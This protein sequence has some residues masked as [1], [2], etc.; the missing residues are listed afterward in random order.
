[1]PTTAPP[2]QRSHTRP[3]FVPA[4][5]AAATFADLAE[6]WLRSN[7]HIKTSSRRTYEIQL[8]CQIHPHIGSHN[9][10]TL[11]T[12][13]IANLVWSLAD[14]GYSP[15]TIQNAYL[16]VKAVL[17]HGIRQQLLNTNPAAL[18]PARERPRIG[19]SR[20]RT[21]NAA[22]INAL[23]R[24]AREPY[25]TIFTLA[26]FSGLRSGEVRGLQWHDIDFANDR[27][28]VRRQAQ[29]GQLVPPK[30]ANAARTVALLE[31]L[32]HAL[33]IYKATQDARGSGSNSDLL[34]QANGKPFRS[35]RL[36]YTLRATAERAGIQQHP[37]E[38]PLRFHD[39][40]HTCASIL[41]AS[42]ADIAFIAQQLGHAS[43]ATTLQTYAHLFDERGNLR[44]VHTYIAEE[45]TAAQI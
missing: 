22:E 10:A 44:R 41:I 27:I 28:Q 24:T 21:L 42:R 23:L 35:A 40:R 25:K 11:T 45:L 19:K 43:P 15:V 32:K 3:R 29:N 31:P 9:A 6:L 38:P 8:R 1:M 33:A 34:F 17:D 37:D 4:P 12:E 13:Q 36:W 26:I 5:G 39:L 2:T 16:L 18:L 14:S 7:R 30:T 20:A